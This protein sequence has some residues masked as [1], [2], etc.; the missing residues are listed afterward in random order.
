MLNALPNVENS[1]ALG[2]IKTGTFTNFP[3]RSIMR[4]TV[5]YIC[6]NKTQTTEYTYDDNIIEDAD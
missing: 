2:K 6:D 4:I 1:M 5:R 3:Q